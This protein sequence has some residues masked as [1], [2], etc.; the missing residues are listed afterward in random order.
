[1]ATA[2]IANE[3]IQIISVAEGTAVITVS[4][5]STPPHTATIAVTVAADGTITIGTITK[6]SSFESNYT[7]VTDGNTFLVYG[8][9]VISSKYINRDDVKVGRPILDLN[10]V[11]GAELIVQANATS[12]RWNSAAGE[13]IVELFRSLNAS[14]KMGYEGWRLA[15]AWKRSSAFPKTTKARPGTPKGRVSILPGTNT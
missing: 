7:P 6:Y 13:S 5:S 1:V 15:A 10:K 11:N 4:D 14:A 3:K 12:S 8:Y 9:N 2:A